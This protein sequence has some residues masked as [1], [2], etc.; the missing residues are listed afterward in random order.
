MHKRLTDKGPNLTCIHAPV[1]IVMSNL[2]FH[3]H[4]NYPQ[5]VNRLVYIYLAV[6]ASAILGSFNRKNDQ[7]EDFKCDERMHIL[8]VPILIRK[9]CNYL[10]LFPTILA[11]VKLISKYFEF[12]KKIQ[13][14]EPYISP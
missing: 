5:T 12:L 3:I 10:F 9:L 13:W 4:N 11:P 1:N 8:H 7:A 6:P 2:Q 14:T